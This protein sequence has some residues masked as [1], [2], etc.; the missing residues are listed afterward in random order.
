MPRKIKV[1][2]MNKDEE[3]GIMRKEITLPNVVFE[4]PSVSLDNIRQKR[5][6]T[7]LTVNEVTRRID[8]RVINTLE[9]EG[10]TPF[11]RR[12]RS[13]F[14]PDKLNLAIFDLRFDS[15]PNKPSLITLANTLY[16]SSDLTIFL[17][18]VKG[19]LLK[20]DKRLSIERVQRHIEMMEFL[21][22]E[23]E[24]VGNQKELIGTIPL[25]P[26]KFSRP[27]IDLYHNKGIKS[28]AIDAGTKDVLLNEGDF[29]LILSEINHKSPLEENFIYACNLGFSQFEEEEIRADDFLSLFAYVDVL[30]GSFKPRGGGLGM[31]GMKPRPKLFSRDRYSYKI[32]TLPK[33]S[34][35]VGEEISYS[36]LKDYNRCEQLRETDEVRF[37]V[38]EE[39]MKRHLMKKPAVDRLAIKRLE[40]IASNLE[41]RL[42]Q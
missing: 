10:T 23:I 35:I 1:R 34:E 7:T 3:L 37:R 18:T 25:I 22:D 28:F 26:I 15:F 19:G 24:S 32:T 39:S 27:I 2:E 21:I 11:V 20:E 38:G 41:M 14:L 36:S 8:Q 9:V 33:A 13:N 40:S 29:R 12:I 16:A 30:G 42:D 31:R 5:Y 4:T 17:P 6:P